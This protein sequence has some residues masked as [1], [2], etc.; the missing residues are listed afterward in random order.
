VK[1]EEVLELSF[2]TAFPNT[3]PPSL[4]SLLA[5]TIMNGVFTPAGSVARHFFFRERASRTAEPPHV[6]FIQSERGGPIKIGVAND[7][8]ARLGSLQAAH[9]HRLKV[10]AVIQRG[11]KATERGLHIRFATDRLVGEWFEDSQALQEVIHGA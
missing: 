8:M 1:I 9:P 10:L 3:C 6:Y 5:G 4:R 11:G 7:I 2:G